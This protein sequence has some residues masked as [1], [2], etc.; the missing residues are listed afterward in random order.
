MGRLL[1]F[2]S[3][4]EKEYERLKKTRPSHTDIFKLLNFEDEID[5]DYGIMVKVKRASDRKQFTLPLTKL[6]APDKKSKNYQLLNDYSVW[7]V[8]F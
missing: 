6:K 8:N 5:S 1:C 3:G 2:R 4:D 7:F